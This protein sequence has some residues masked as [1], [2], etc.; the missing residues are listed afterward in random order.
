MIVRMIFILLVF[1]ALLG[2]NSTFAQNT[3]ARISQKTVVNGQTGAKIDELLTRYAMY[4]FSGTV[5]IIKNDQ[6]VIHKAYGLADRE[7]RRVDALDTLYDV[8]SIAKTF[9]A[10]AVL[11][12]EMQGKLKT[13]DPIGKYLGE[14][15]ADKAGITIHHLLPPTAGC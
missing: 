11:Q 5:L 7:T 3:N 1:C 4:G 2:A 10:S 12:L 15:P 13:T 8:G 9:T 14:F 6:V